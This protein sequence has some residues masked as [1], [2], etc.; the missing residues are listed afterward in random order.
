MLILFR[1]IAAN[2]LLFLTL[3]LSLPSSSL[4]QVP[5]PAPDA[6]PAAKPAVDPLGRDT[7]A[8]MVAGFLAAVQEGNY[9]RAAQYLHLADG[10][11]GGPL[12]ARKL[13]Y[14]LD[15]G[16][17]IESR[18]RLST[19]R[20][21]HQDDG[22]MPD[23][24]RFGVVRT[25]TG[26]FTLIAERVTTPAGQIWLVSSATVDKLPLLFTTV[27]ASLLDKLL[28]ESLKSNPF[29]GVPV[30]HWLAL[31][32]ITVAAYGFTW[33]LTVILGP[34]LL[35]PFRRPME[36]RIGQAL[37]ASLVPIRLFVSI[38]IAWIAATLVGVSIVARQ[39]FSGVAEAVGWVALAWILWRV[40]DTFAAFSADRMA[41]RGNSSMLAGVAFIRRSVKA[42]IV[43]VAGLS[44]LGAMGFNVSAGLAALGI[45]GIAIALGAQ[46]TIE[47]FVGS[48]S[49][50]ADQPV[51]VGEFCRFG[52]TLGT[53]EDIGMRSTRIRTL[54]RTLVSVPNGQFSSMQIEN[55]SRRDRFWFHPVLE[56]RYETTAAQMRQI[57]S[58]LRQLL[59]DR[60]EV[61]SDTAR[62]RLLNLAASSLQVEIYSYVMA[63]DFGQFLEIQEDLIL[64]VMDIV[65]RAGSGFAFNSQT[66][67]I[68]RDR[69]PAAPKD[70]RTSSAAA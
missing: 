54:S 58:D 22:L 64:T 17:Y 18:L 28:P 25:P 40:V 33:L 24:E 11:T 69:G 9:E 10:A 66:V 47:H 60:E 23:Q 1:A 3:S 51:R 49:L 32:A 27:S 31:V 57:L 67:Y 53:V 43:V 6:P 44:L 59:A 63:K 5:G 41:L 36:S 34:L 37:S 8:G 16:G 39:H 56:L 68:A 46:K 26:E 50:V 4:A 15:R 42:A 14:V 13:Q 35:R 29:W 38:W 70:A 52:D 45:G 21:G 62:V 55:Y 7:P 12:L 2:L 61:I 20:N 65:E 19:D 30:G 48:L